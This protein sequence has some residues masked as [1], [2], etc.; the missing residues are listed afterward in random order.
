M[1]KRMILGWMLVA[2]MV[3]ALAA[4]KIWLE[5][6]DRSA[7]TCGRRAT[8]DTRP[9]SRVASAPTRPARTAPCTSHE[10]AARS[11]VRSGAEST[12]SQAHS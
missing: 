11:A 7:M 9:S 2:G 4:E 8:S 10:C 12:C 5:D 3:P 6:V 1:K